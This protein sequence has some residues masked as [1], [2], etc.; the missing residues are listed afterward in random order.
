M[1]N[2]N[3]PLIKNILRHSIAYLVCSEYF[4]VTNNN[5]VIFENFHHLHL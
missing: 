4:D 5:T 3:L 1:R 2:K